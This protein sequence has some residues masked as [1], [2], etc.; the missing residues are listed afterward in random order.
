MQ[1]TTKNDEITESKKNN[2]VQ[3]SW[4]NQETCRAIHVIA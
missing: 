4:L 3:E 1:E 2:K